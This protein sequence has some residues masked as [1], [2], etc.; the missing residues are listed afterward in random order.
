MWRDADWRVVR[1]CGGFV[2]GA[3]ARAAGASLNAVRG[4]RFVRVLGC[5]GA[6]RPLVRVLRVLHVVLGVRRCLGARGKV[7]QLPRRR[8]CRRS[9]AR[10]ARTRGRPTIC[11]HGALRFSSIVHDELA[12]HKSIRASDA[13]YD[14][15]GRIRNLGQFWLPPASQIIRR[16]WYAQTGRIAFHVLCQLKRH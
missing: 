12:K 4:S 1:A 14:A 7:K 10:A 11:A 16:V 9:R 5:A 8:D 2:W 13:A 6:S 3:S 15:P